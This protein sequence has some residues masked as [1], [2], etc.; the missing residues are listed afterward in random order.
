MGLTGSRLSRETKDG[1]S[2]FI[3]KEKPFY[4]A[5]RDSDKPN[6]DQSLIANIK[7]AR[8]QADDI[9]DEMK[10]DTIH[11]LIDEI[12]SKSSDDIT[13]TMLHK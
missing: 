2:V 10:R 13:N 7:S 12:V 4:G 11:R 9:K 6:V 1:K 8:R 3:I 5:E